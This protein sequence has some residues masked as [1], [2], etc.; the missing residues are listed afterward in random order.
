MNYVIEG[1]L[2]LFW[3]TFFGLHGWLLRAP[4]GDAADARTRSDPDTLQGE[5]HA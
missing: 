3:L 4:D 1:T 5:T 2:V